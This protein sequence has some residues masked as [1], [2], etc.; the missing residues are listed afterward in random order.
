M[1]VIE[2]QYLDHWGLTITSISNMSGPVLRSRHGTRGPTSADQ[3]GD[4]SVPV[5]PTGG[6]SPNGQPG[7]SFVLV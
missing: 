3:M 2:A 7:M 1:Q 5:A 6:V 4:M